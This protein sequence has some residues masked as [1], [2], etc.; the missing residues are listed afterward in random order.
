[1]A[2]DFA[3]RRKQAEDAG[4]IGGGD[5]YKYREGDNRIRLLSEC[6]PHTSFFNGQKSFKWL[7]YVLDRREGKVKAHFMP[8][9]IYKAIEAFQTSEDYT[10]TD[11]PMPYDI[12]VN[13][14][15]A[16]TKDVVYTVIPAKKETP[17]KA[18]ELADLAKQKS[19]KELK[20]A[21]KDS[22]EKK[23]ALAGRSEESHD[24]ADIIDEP[25]F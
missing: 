15:G 17:L 8:H 5:F 1:M 7:C 16:G 14:K 23:A 4:L 6:E 3:A 24:E 22:A 12:T 10:F 25:P 20:Q 9:K 21:L 2:V 19:L 13:A 11:V 18:E